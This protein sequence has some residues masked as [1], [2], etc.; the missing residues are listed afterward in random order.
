MPKMSYIGKAWKRGIPARNLS[1]EEVEKYGGVE[2]LTKT[3]LYEVI[4]VR[5]KKKSVELVAET[6]GYIVL[7]DEITEA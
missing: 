7:D 6:K 5:K 2:L 4:K 3:G 1:A